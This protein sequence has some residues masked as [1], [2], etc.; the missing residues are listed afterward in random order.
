MVAVV[1]KMKLAEKL[2]GHKG[3]GPISTV[4]HMSEEEGQEMKSMTLTV[5]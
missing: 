4:K 3:Y 5:G 2:A 1:P